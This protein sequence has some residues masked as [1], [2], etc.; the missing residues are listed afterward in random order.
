[1]LVC[2]AQGE[3]GTP[4]GTDGIFTAKESC[5]KLRSYELNGYQQ[6]MMKLKFVGIWLRICVVAS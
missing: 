1:M 3:G 6:E 4:S 2:M 5:S